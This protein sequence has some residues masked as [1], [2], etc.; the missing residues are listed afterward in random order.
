M[1]AEH[2][3]QFMRRGTQVGPGDLLQP[4]SPIIT[5]IANIPQQLVVELVTPALTPEAWEKFQN[6]CKSNC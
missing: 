6:A 2:V 4:P 5:D 3:D 1:A